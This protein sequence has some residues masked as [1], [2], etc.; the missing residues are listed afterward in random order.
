MTAFV[1]RRLLQSILVMLVVSLV[2]FLVFRYVGDPVASMVGQESRIE[3]REELRQRLYDDAVKFAKAMN[4]RNAG[5]VEFLVDTEGER[6][7]Q[8]ARRPQ[9]V[10]VRLLLRAVERLRLLELGLK[11]GCVLPPVL[12]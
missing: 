10:Q 2:A 6:A 1:I 4:Y 5:T 12:R 8:H 7:G 3:D 9:K 11:G